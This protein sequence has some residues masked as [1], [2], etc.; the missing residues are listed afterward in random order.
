[1]TNVQNMRLGRVALAGTLLVTGG[2]VWVVH[3]NQK[4]ERERMFEGVKRDME[5]QRLK[6][7]Q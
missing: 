4:A 7:L 3:N 6:K 5:R 2:V 1:M